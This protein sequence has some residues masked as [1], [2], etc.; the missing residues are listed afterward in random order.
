MKILRPYHFFTVCLLLVCTIVP[1][2]AENVL[3][4]P[5]GDF[6]TVGI[7]I[8][9]LEGDTVVYETNSNLCLMPASI[10]KAYTT[11]TAMSLKNEDFRFETKVYTTGAVTD[12]GTLNGNIVVKASGDPTLESE[13]FPK[14]QGFISEI[15]KALKDKGIKKINGEIILAKVNE[16]GKYDEG[17]INTWCIDDTEYKYGAG[18]FDFNWSGNYQMKYPFDTFKKRLIERLKSNGITYSGKKSAATNRTLLMTHESP[19][20]DDILKNLMHRSD[21][22]F[23]EGMLR[24]IGEPY[25][26]KNNALTKESNLWKSRGLQPQ[27]VNVLDGSGLSRANAISPVYMASMLEW[28]A[29]SDMAQRY[30][31]VFPVAGE[32]GTMRSFLAQTPLKGRL[33]MKT[34]SVNN[35]QCYAGY[36]TDTDGQP[37]HV[38]VVMVNNFFCQRDQVKQAIQKMLLN[39]LLPWI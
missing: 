33:A 25:G 23:A 21:N 26:P 20:I 19:V 36:L 30:V 9:D 28:M 8:K 5:G 35:V 38:V 32:S 10:T 24:A 39:K 37:T 27:Y 31:N 18:I 4:I 11:A 34:G 6:T 12:D 3:G 22:M 29:R 1:I 13:Q 16:S 2:K 15:V 14:N 7:Y 17:A